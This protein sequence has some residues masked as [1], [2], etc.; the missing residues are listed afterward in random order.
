MV[1][2][3]VAGVQL[4]YSY[5][6]FFIGKQKKN[7]KNQSRYRGVDVAWIVHFLQYVETIDGSRKSK[8]DQRR[9][10]K[11]MPK[12]SRLSIA[13]IVSKNDNTAAPVDGPFLDDRCWHFFSEHSKSVVVPGMSDPL[14][15]WC[16]STGGNTVCGRSRNNSTLLEETTT[17]STRTS[18]GS[19]A[20]IGC[21]CSNLLRRRS[22]GRIAKTSQRSSLS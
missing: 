5:I 11:F 15:L 4:T 9:P 18:A 8:C 12:T 14:F 16:T 10:E 19:F 3:R 1:G 6:V 17:G 13:S 2:S 7:N 22:S 21:A 20:K